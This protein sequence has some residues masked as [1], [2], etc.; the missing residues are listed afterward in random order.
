MQ[1]SKTDPLPAAVRGL[2]EA[3]KAY[4]VLTAQAAVEGDRKLA[5]QALWAHRLV[6]SYESAR[7]LLEALL[8]AHRR[9]LP[10]FFPGE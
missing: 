1:P 9:Y 4:E 2:V 7:G 6:P 5:L 8:Q 10:Q 3:V